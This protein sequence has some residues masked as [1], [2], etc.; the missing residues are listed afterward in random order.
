MIPILYEAG[1][2]SFTSNGIGRLRDCVTCVVTEERNGIYECDFTYPID[3]AYFKDIV[4][5]RIIAVTHD[6]NGDVQPFDIVSYSKPID[7][8]AS[9]HA[10]HI[11]YRQSFMTA[12]GKH[13]WS[14]ADAFT[15]LEGAEPDNPFTYSTDITATG[16][17]AAADGTPKTVRQLLGGSEGSIL[18]SYGGEYEF[19]GFQV[20]L[21]RNRG[22]TRDFVIRYG[23]NMTDYT[24]D[25]DFFGTFNSCIPF[26]N[27]EGG[28]I[29]GARVD[30]DLQT[31]N[32]S[33]LCVPLDLTDKFEDIPTALQLA[34]EAMAYMLDQQPNLAQQNIKINFLRLQD[35]SGYE[36][37]ENLLKC[38]LCDTISVVF[39][40]Y[41]MTGAFK[42][43]RVVWD[44]LD[45][46]YVEMELG[47]LQTTL[48]EALGISSQSASGLSSGG[49]AL[50]R[51]G[52]CSTGGSAQAKVATV[53][54]GIANLDTGTMIFVKFTNANTKANPTLNVN[55]TGAKSIM[56]YGTTAPSTSAAS[57]WNAGSVVAFV[58]D[59]TYW[60]MVGWI[61]TTYSAMTQAEMQTG[62]STSSRLIT[63][64]RLKEAILYWAT[65]ANIGAMSSSAIIT[66]SYVYSG[67]SVTSFSFSDANVDGKTRIICGAQDAGNPPL[68]ASISGDT[69]TVYV[70]DPVS[71][72]RVNYICF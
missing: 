3:G 26:W 49:T 40:R 69:I 48:A 10:V 47:A 29:V 6:D 31:F 37:Y 41:N 13:I 28:P 66:G 46:R 15:L 72:M 30:S 54:P 50:V 58:Y 52:T 68:R 63:P 59:G 5:G 42:I 45:G 51:Y 53:T 36:D 11:S 61:N 34:T 35:F 71:L 23:V 9:F 70:S 55:G 39:P 43:V 24:D 20:I 33:T 8:V 56:R 1:E 60:Q 32:G 25:T 4:P 67:A 19:N 64:A 27:G 65:P 16:L 21:H 62:T 17:L 14:L 57:S 7:G 2:T 44:V 22:V 12:T 18:D 38:N